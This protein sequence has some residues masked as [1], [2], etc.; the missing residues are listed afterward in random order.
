MTVKKGNS[1]NEAKSFRPAPEGR[2]TLIFQV[3]FPA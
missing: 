2:K 3:R 1:G